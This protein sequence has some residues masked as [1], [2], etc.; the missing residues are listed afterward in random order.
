[1]ECI[2]VNLVVDNYNTVLSSLLDSHAPLKTAYVTSRILQ[3][4]MSEE[5]L[6]VTRE[7]RK[8]ERIWRKT[9]LTVHLKIFRALCLKLKTLIYDAKEKCYKKQISDCDRDQKQL[10]ALLTL[11]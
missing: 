9:K 7:K 8:S 5:I 4:W 3:P 1:M 10:L 11:F 6:S 2:D